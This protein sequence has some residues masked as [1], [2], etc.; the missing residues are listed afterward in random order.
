MRGDTGHRGMWRWRD[1]NAFTGTE[2]TER[3]DSPGTLGRAVVGMHL[4]LRLPA[5]APGLDQDG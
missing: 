2:D 5:S 3:R 4:G 1:P